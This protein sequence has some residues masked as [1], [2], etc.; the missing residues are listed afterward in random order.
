MRVK[1]SRIGNLLSRLASSVLF[2]V[3]YGKIKICCV[4]RSAFERLKNSFLMLLQN[5]LREDNIELDEE[6]AFGLV[7]DWLKLS[8]EVLD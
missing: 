2:F 4:S 7:L 8:F 3:S 5:A 6:A 1:I